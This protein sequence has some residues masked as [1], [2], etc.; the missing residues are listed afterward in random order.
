MRERVN[1]SF[2][3]PKRL[4]TQSAPHK[5]QTNAHTKQN[6]SIH[7]HTGCSLSLLSLSH[8]HT[9]THTHPLVSLMPGQYMR[10]RI[11]SARHN[12]VITKICGR[13]IEHGDE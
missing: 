6:N 10:F 1:K 9:H 8:T 2:K 4:R 13:A 11:K 3:N 7:V 5:W 12:I